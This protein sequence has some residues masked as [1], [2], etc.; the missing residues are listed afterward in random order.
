MAEEIEIKLALPTSLP[1]A[2]RALLRHPLL[3]QASKLGTRKLL[4]IYFDTPDFLLHKHAIALRTR[5]QGRQWL[6]TV[7]CA[8]NEDADPST[9]S[10][11]GLAVRPE[12]EQPYSG[13]FDF[14]GVDNK[15]VRALLERPKVRAAL[16]PIFETTFSR[17]TWRL[18]P[19]QGSTVLLMLDQGSIQANGA[20]ETIAEVELELEHGEAAHL[21]DL[22]MT[23]CADIALQPAVLSK[24]ERGF[25]LYGGAVLAPV[26]AVGSAVRRDQTPWEAFRTI[27]AACLLQLQLN[28]LGAEKNDIEFIHQMRVALRRLR[29]ALRTF[30]PIITPEFMAIAVPRIRTLAR[31][32]GHARDHDVLQGEILA[33]VRRALPQ[34]A[35]VAALCAAMEAESQTMRDHARAALASTEHAQLLLSFAALLHAQKSDVG[36]EAI[37]HFAARRLDKLHKKLRQLAQAAEQLDVTALHAL[38]VGCKRLRYAIEFFAPLYREKGVQRT[39]ATLVTL[40]NSLG[41]LND[42]ASAGAPLMQCAGNDATLREAVTLIGGWHGPRY[43]TLRAMLPGRIGALLK[44]KRHWRH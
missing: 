24:A 39:L 33:P 43:E 15:K 2:R 36:A 35:R 41:A 1:T 20:T 3:T 14:S 42:L 31:A 6:Q 38:R 27:T 29:A 34:E 16:T 30:A 37:L 11:G 32:L 21:F 5:K 28:E 17:S 25:R 44:M 9:S 13:S 26:K 22:A 8:H 19:A 7:K 12:W 4:N 10:V 40:Q 23:L 18:S